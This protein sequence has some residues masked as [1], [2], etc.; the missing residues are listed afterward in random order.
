MAYLPAAAAR[1]GT[2]VAIEVR[3]RPT[4]AKIV[5]KRVFRTDRR[6]IESGRNRMRQRD[7]PVR[8]L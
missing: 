1:P 8:I 5:K 6:V 4:P 2:P 3:G 7:L